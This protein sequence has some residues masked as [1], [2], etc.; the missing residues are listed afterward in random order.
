MAG[1]RF[2]GADAARPGPAVLEA[3]DEAETI[4]VCPSNPVV[5]IGPLLAVPGVLDC[6]R[7]R[8]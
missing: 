4:V 7:R 2:E 5:S 3:L 8:R 1:V 6:V